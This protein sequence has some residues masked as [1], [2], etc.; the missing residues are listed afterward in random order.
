MSDFSFE[1]RQASQGIINAA[2]MVHDEFSKVAMEQFDK[3]ELAKMFEVVKGTGA[4]FGKDGGSW[5]YMAGELSEPDCIVGWGETPYRALSAFYNEFRRDKQTK[6][7][8][9]E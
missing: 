2:M 3:E 4:K 5:F 1:A 9:D 6:G 7:G 8:G